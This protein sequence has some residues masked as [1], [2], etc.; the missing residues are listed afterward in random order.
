[1]SKNNYSIGQVSAICNISIQGLR[2][3]DKIDLL[4]P[5]IKNSAN[6]YRYYTDTDIIYL[7][8]IQDLKETGF[9][10][11]EIKKIIKTDNTRDILDVLS[12]KRKE[13]HEKL[14]SVNLILE[15]IDERIAN[16]QL[17]NNTVN[18]VNHFLCIEIKRLPARKVIYTRYESNSNHETLSLRFYELDKILKKY[19]IVANGSRMA[20]YHDSSNNSPENYDLEVCIPI[21]EN[22]G[23]DENHI[24]NIDANLYAT[25]IYQG[26]YFGQCDALKNWINNL[27]YQITGPAIEIYL[28]SFMNT[29]F[30]KQFVTEIQI[31][32][33]KELTL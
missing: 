7:R 31:P 6:C 22:P 32:V 10:L 25:A 17:S 16:L 12:K 3:Y 29:R 21:D 18:N 4:K 19:P 9:S 26:E 30:P 24:R 8:I 20:I 14:Q 1:M 13:F 27:H 15:R 33:K 23:K 5:S 2:Y 28:N 11:D